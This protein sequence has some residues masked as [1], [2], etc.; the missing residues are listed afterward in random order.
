MSDKYIL[1]EHGEPVPCEDLLEWARWLETNRAQRVVKK[2]EIDGSR[3]STV[4]LGL[5]HSFGDGPP[6]IFETLVFDGPMDGEMDRYSTRIEALIGHAAMVE[7]VRAAQG[8]NEVQ[9]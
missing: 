4:F 2:D 1:N 5:D 3:V 6:V 9:K 8:K 7:R